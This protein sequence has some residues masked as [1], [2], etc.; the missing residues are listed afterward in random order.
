MKDVLS[1]FVLVAPSRAIPMRLDQHSNPNN[2]DTFG[3]GYQGML[4]H[5]FLAAALSLLGF[6]L[7]VSVGTFTP[8]YRECQRNYEETYP[9]S[10]K[11]DYRHL[12]RVIAK[13]EGASIDANS[14]TITAVGTI[15]IAAFT[16]TLWLV[17]G[18]SLQL[19]RDEF[20]S[21]HRPKLRMRLLQ[22]D[23]PQVNGPF[24]ISFTMANIGDTAA[25]IVGVDV[26]IQVRNVVKIFDA[27]GQL[28]N[29]EDARWTSR[30]PRGQIIPAGDSAILH[31]ESI[32]RFDPEWG[33]PTEDWALGTV[34]II[35]AIT[36]SDDRRINRRTGFYRICTRSLHRFDLFEDFT[37][38][39]LRDFE[40]ED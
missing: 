32:E 9:G 33:V 23:A 6:V 28:V 37:E 36:Y 22:M 1:A 16:L 21:S 35:G 34:A 2:S 27:E 25:T 31:G 13:C 20:I 19:A 39:Q 7:L 26:K 40:Y 17:T 30:F 5:G 12:I 18:R 3:E 11:P 38:A 10:A 15:L 14:A 29:Y 4:R 24:K 8:S